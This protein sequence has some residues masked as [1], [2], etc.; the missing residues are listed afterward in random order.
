MPP[1]FRCV[2]AALQQQLLL[3]PHPETVKGREPGPKNK[4]TVPQAPAP[5]VPLPQ[6]PPPQG[7]APQVPVPQ[8]PVLPASQDVAFPLGLLDTLVARVA[9]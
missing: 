9:D 5:Q 3:L 7:P 2:L 8:V 6:V 1:H 4:K